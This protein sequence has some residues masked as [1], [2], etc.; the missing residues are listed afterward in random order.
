[1]FPFTH[2]ERY[3][4]IGISA[5]VSWRD[6]FHVPFQN[7][8]ELDEDWRLTTFEKSVLMPTYLVCFIVCDFSYQE[9][10]IDRTGVSV[11]FAI[12]PVTQQLQISLMLLGIIVKFILI[13]LVILLYHYY[14]VR[15]YGSPLDY[16]L[17]PV[18]SCT[19]LPCPVK[20]VP[21]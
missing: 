17:G 18:C 10:F 1:M 4:P 3:L 14:Y 15:C 20:S 9:N 13:I 7:V 2:L 12:L 21:V 19:V 16:R 11:S 6:L 5:M 8:Q